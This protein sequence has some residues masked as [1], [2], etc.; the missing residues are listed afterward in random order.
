[1][2]KDLR[3]QDC[4]TLLVYAGQGPRPTRCTECRK[5]VVLAARKARWA[6]EKARRGAGDRNNAQIPP[7]VVALS[8]R[9]AVMEMVK[10]LL[11]MAI[12]SGE[13]KKVV[14]AL[15]YLEAHF[16]TGEKVWSQN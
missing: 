4:G 8:E 2:G 9:I 13:W 6:R 15:T 5:V 1:M 10:P 16:T 11:R 7:L 14:E 3:C 12:Q